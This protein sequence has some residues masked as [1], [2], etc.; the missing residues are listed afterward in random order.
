MLFQKLPQDDVTKVGTVLRGRRTV[1]PRNGVPQNVAPQ[2]AA[3]RLTPDFVG[4]HIGSEFVV[5]YGLDF[6]GRYR[7]LPDLHVLKRRAA[8]RGRAQS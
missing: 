6:D 5:G 4:F 7:N 1:A 3:P 8:N 2:T